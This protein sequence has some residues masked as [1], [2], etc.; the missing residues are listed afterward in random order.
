MADQLTTAERAAGA[1]W[2]LFL[3]DALAMPAHW[4]YDR[5]ALRRDYGEIRDMVAPLPRHP[6]SILHRSHYE[7]INPDADILHD[8]AR[9]W[10]QHEVHYHQ[11]LNAGENTLNLQLVQVLLDLLDEQGAYSA[12]N[13]LQEMIA[14]MRDPDS[15][16]DTYV[17]EWA[18]GFFT[19]RAQG[20]SLGKCGVEEKH[21]GGLAGATA[22]LITYHADP[23]AGRILAHE[24]LQLTHKGT[25]MAKALEAVADILQPV[26]AGKPLVQAVDQARRKN[27]NRY[28]AFDFS[29]YARRDDLEVVGRVLS[30]A[31]YIEDAV[32]AVFYLA[33]KYAGKPEEG[34]VT[35]TMAGGDNCYRGA[36]LGALLGA[37][38]GLEAWPLRWRQD[39]K[40]HPALPLGGV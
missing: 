25:G 24:H 4:Y 31:C 34:L 2:G 18:R 38:S 10:G 27:G 33:R 7:P 3:G 11:F 30:P 17:E 20:V 28:L 8:Q 9:Y 36:I 37:E 14:F 15:H 23:D 26:L 1:L 16:R 29:G 35:N 22:L 21:I 32:P 40:Y 5:Q 39:L 6:G 13:Y 12:D 19:R